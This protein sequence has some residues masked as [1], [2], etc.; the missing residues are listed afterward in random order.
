MIHTR[1]DNITKGRA[2]FQVPGQIFEIDAGGDGSLVPWVLKEKATW[3]KFINF[4]PSIPAAQQ[5]DRKR[6][7]QSQAR[8][9]RPST[10]T[11]IW[12]GGKCG[13]WAS[14]DLQP[15][16]NCWCWWY[17]MMTAR[18]LM[19]EDLSSQDHL[20]SFTL[21]TILIGQGHISKV[22]VVAQIFKAHPCHSYW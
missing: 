15:L 6:F 7:V 11:G 1:K 21:L 20:V 17:V 13:S 18:W 16:A 8:L 14:D 19:R 9:A 12:A 2:R 22:V 3:L 4:L 5:P 10:P